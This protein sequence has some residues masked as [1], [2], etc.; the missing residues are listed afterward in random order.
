VR[1]VITDL[2]VLEPDPES[3]ELTVTELHPGVTREQII[4]ATGWTLRFADG[5][6]T[7]ADPTEDELSALRALQAA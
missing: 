4:D 2:G 3:C 5:V 7:T 1:W 6:T